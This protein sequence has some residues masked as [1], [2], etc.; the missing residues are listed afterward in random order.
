[1]KLD[2]LIVRL[3]ALYDLGHGDAWVIDNRGNDVMDVKAPLPAD[4]RQGADPDEA[5]AVMIE[6]YVDYDR[7]H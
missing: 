1:M 2:D 7:R 6:C 5:D 4:A 3:Q